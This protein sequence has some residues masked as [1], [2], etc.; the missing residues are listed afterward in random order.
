[1]Q[2][3]IRNSNAFVIFPG[4]SGTVQEM[5]A[6]M[7]FKQHGHPSM[8]GKPVI[9]FNRKD[10]R[11]QSFWTPLI[12]MLATWCYEGEFIVVDELHELIP[13]VQNFIVSSKIV[14]ADAR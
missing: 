5:L 11:G 14:V 9:I 7:I 13:T 6:L 10:A 4:G 2:V 8:I 12:E 1:M 3:M